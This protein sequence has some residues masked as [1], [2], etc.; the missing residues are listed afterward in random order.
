VTTDTPYLRKTVSVAIERAVP[1][2]EFVMMTDA[3]ARCIF[4]KITPSIN[5]ADLLPF[6][7][8]GQQSFTEWVTLQ[9]TLDLLDD[10]DSTVLDISEDMSDRAEL[11]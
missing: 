3:V 10:D 9:R 6:L 8:R 7:Q 5:I 2:L 4:D 11:D 1:G